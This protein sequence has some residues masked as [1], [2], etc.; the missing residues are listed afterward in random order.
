MVCTIKDNGVGRSHKN[1]ENNLMKKNRVNSIQIVKRRLEIIQEEY[2]TETSII[3]K[4]LI[5]GK[6]VE[7]TEVII[8]IPYIETW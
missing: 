1:Q 7:G 8:K 4:D 3:I 5:Q 6:K 2:K